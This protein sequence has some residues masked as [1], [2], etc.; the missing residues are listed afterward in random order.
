MGRMD[1]AP[2]VPLYPGM[3]LGRYLLEQEIGRG[4]MGVVYRAFDPALDRRVA[5]KTVQPVL[6]QGSAE[7]NSFERRFQA[8]AR[9]AASL[10]HPAIVVVHDVGRDEATGALFIAFE[11]LPG[12]TLAE[13]SAAHGALPW[14]EALALGQQVARGLQHAHQRGIVHR[15]IKPANVMVLPT[16]EPKIMDFGIAKLDQAH[17]TSP[18]EAFGTPLYMS[19]EQVLGEPLDARS[20]VFALGAV[21]Y[22]LLTGRRAF[23]A[24]HVPGI[25]QRVTQAQPTPPSQ[26]ASMPAGCDAVLARALE[27]SREARWPS[28]Q[29]FAEALA[30]LLS[31]TPT[32]PVSS[33]AG[34]LAHATATLAPEAPTEREAPTLDLHAADSPLE[35]L[36]EGPP[37]RS[38]PATTTPAALPVPRSGSSRR[39]PALWMLGGGALLLALLTLGWLWRASQPSTATNPTLPLLGL[40][41]PV[42]TPTPVR[43][44]VQF[45][46]PLRGGTLR[47]RVDGTQVFEESLESRVTRRVLFVK[48]RRGTLT[49]TFEVVPGARTFEVLVTSG[50]D[51][52]S[53]TLTAELSAGEARRLFVRL[54]DRLI[55]SHELRAAWMD[56]RP[57]PS[58][59]P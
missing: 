20:D 3:T 23:D 32:S 8:E 26:L 36:L 30:A 54:E 58:P 12:Q 47:V 35:A 41:L 39:R 22:L 19:P 37:E 51:A 34:G 17:L 18:G 29:A 4:T 14:R 24:P 44:E 50:N 33:A 46:H 40:P 2:S 13:L 21:L 48:K 38:Q 49:G 55:G 7:R 11:L 28:A 57:S 31:A 9:L 16:G 53:R 59:E 10:S 43:I 45:E 52:W 25:L 15:D 6:A 42:P 56:V 1:L 5:L 27:K